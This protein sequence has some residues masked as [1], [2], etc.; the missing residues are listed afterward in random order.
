VGLIRRITSS[1]PE[2][3]EEEITGSTKSQ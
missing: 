2:L 3:N 1:G